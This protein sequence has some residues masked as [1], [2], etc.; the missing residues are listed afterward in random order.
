MITKQQKQELIQK[1]GGDARNSGDT[2]AQIA[3]LTSRI[4]D[5]TEHLRRHPKDNHSRR[6]LILLVGK[7]RRL[8]RYLYHKDYQR[9]LQVCEELGIRRPF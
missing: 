8:L 6:G 3:I 2:A 5:I 1:F 4:N 9:Y 7:R